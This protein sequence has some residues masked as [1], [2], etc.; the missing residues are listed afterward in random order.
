MYSDS[1]EIGILSPEEVWGD[2]ILEVIKRFGYNFNCTD[3][4]KNLS[5]YNYPEFY[6]QGTIYEEHWRSRDKYYVKCF[7][8]NGKEGKCLLPEW[9]GIILPV[10]KYPL[11]FEKLLPKANYIDGYYEV[12][13]GEYPQ[14]LVDS[15]MQ[16]EL[17]KKFY[18][19]KKT[20]K[21]YHLKDRN[22]GFVPFDEYEY[23]GRKYVFL[24]DTKRRRIWF[25][26][27][28]I[29]WLMDRQKELFICQKGILSGI[30]LN[31][32]Y[33]LS[34]DIKKSHL[35]SFMYESMLEDIL[36]SVNI[37]LLDDEKS[38][39]DDN[40]GNNI[41]DIN[42]Y[43][44]DIQDLLYKIDE[45]C[46]NLSDDIKNSI[47]DKVD[48]L[49][50]EYDKAVEETSPVYG[51]S[52]DFIFG[53]NDIGYIKSK[54]L[55]N[56]EFIIFNLK[57]NDKIVKLESYKELLSQDKLDFIKDADSID[58][59]INNIIYMIN[60][61]PDDKKKKYE[62]DFNT[63]IDTA[64][65]KINSSIKAIIN[66][67][68]D[69]NSDLDIDVYFDLEISKLYDEISK[70]YYNELPYELL[71]SSLEGNN[72]ETEIGEL[73]TGIKISIKSLSSVEYRKILEDKF[74]DCINK[75]KNDLKNILKEKDVK[76]L[77]K[78][79]YNDKELELRKELQFVLK[80][81]KY[82]ELLGAGNPLLEKCNKDN[83]I[84]ELT[85]SKEITELNGRVTLKEDDQNKAITSTVKEL[86]NYIEDNVLNE[87]QK[88]NMRKDIINTINKQLK[89][90]EDNDIN[91]IKDYNN[92]I[93]EIL[94]ELVVKI[95][96]KI[97][98]YIANDK[99]Y[100][101]H[102]K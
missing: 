68:E 24:N 74:N 41:K 51:E 6:T 87:E 50:K 37:E 27:K 89:S 85:E 30:S 11:L 62:K 35:Y 19:M 78:D 88:K 83:I 69:I 14:D 48:A 31:I 49:L 23:N 93:K 64:I 10:I 98:M 66:N 39:E 8:E 7:D 94:N 34:E 40:K 55:T 73:L 76:P 45:I 43:S 33:P 56:L 28:P 42:K 16:K 100:N 46:N 101:K 29:K 57:S 92:K 79:K 91:N 2:N 97:E 22:E 53:K 90:L 80:L 75:Y 3:L 84:K 72:N 9:Y 47:H 4:A 71:L 59:K 99:Y 77:K 102:T 13:F 18:E 65:K 96:V 17:N 67:K 58:S 26:V 15:K 21:S 36:Q 95:G 82:Y 12:E 1:I 5:N 63:I 54:L 60:S 32:G 61:M 44:K 52:N 20:G 38:T 25:E 86:N 81:L 70:Y